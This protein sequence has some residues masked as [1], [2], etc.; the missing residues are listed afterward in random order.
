MLDYLIRGG[1]IV[2]GTGTPGVKGDVGV[3]DGRIVAL[4]GTIDEEAAETLDADGLVV[5]P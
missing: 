1:T 2:D 4:G 3:R 5:A